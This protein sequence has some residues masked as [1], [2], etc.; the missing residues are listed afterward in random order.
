MPNYTD[1]W[2]YWAGQIVTQATV[3]T[4]TGSGF[5]SMGSNANSHQVAIANILIIRRIDYPNFVGGCEL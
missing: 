1:S 4:E 5:L 3:P 2:R